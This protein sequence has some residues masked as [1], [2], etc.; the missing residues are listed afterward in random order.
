MY[1]CVCVYEYTYI[2][3]G[4]GGVAEDA[5]GHLIN[6]IRNRKLSQGSQ[7]QDQDPEI[8]SCGN[9]VSF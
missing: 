1:I 5:T 2:F 4:G 7:G 3:G 8:R 9:P 6:L